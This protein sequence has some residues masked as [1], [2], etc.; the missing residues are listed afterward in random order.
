MTRSLAE[1]QSY[2]DNQ[3]KQADS[4]VSVATGR[5]ISRSRLEAEEFAGQQLFPIRL[6]ETRE[7]ASI[8]YTST[9]IRDIRADEWVDEASS[10]VG[11][12]GAQDVFR[13][14]GTWK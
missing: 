5:S 11:N 6:T 4:L 8:A 3:P 2:L 9:P 1:L 10:R 12:R 14:L 13:R 7:G